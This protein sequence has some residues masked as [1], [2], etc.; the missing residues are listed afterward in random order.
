MSDLFGN[1]IVGFP[2]PNPDNDEP[3][4]VKI[5]AYVDDSQ[6]FNSTENSVKE[7]FKIFDK[8]E[9]ASGAKI[10][11][12][13]TTAMYIGPWKAKQPEFN[14]I[15]WTNTYVKTLGINHGYHIPEHEV[16]ME[17]IK[18]MKNCIQ[19]WKSRDLTLKGKILIIKTFLLSQ[20]N[21]ELEM[22]PIPKQIVKEIDKILWNFLWDGKQ[23]LVNKQTMCLDIE[24]G[25]MNMINLNSFIGAKH[26]KFIHKIVNSETQHWNMIGKY[27]LKHFDKT[28]NSNNFLYNCS[29][30]KGLTINFPSQFYKD[31]IQSWALF[32]NKLQTNHF[33]SILDENICGNNRI[34]HNNTPLWFEL[35]SKNEIKSI[36]D[37]WDVNDKNF[38]DENTILSR[39]TDKRSGLKR[40]RIIKSS[41][42]K[43]WLNTL[44]GNNDNTQVNNLNK[45]KNAIR[46]GTI[47]INNMPLKEIQCLLNENFQPKCIDRWNTVF[48]VEINWNNHWKCSFETPLSNKKKQL[49]WKIIH[50]AI[51]TEYKLSLIGRS[52]G[53]C[54][55]CKTETEYLTHLFCEC[56]V[57]QSAL[58]NINAKVNTI[59]E[60]AGHKHVKFDLKNVILGFNYDT[61]QNVHIRIYLNTVLQMVKWEIWKNRNIIKYENK[62]F[63]TAS[64]LKCIMSKIDCCVKFMQKTKTADKFKK[65]LDLLRQFENHT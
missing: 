35:F 22:N 58:T 65:I 11:K 25:G 1:H 53:K 23:P 8:F 18:K 60:Q 51:F 36:K 4:E 29:S 19:I 32:R 12:T 2:L 33:R 6:Y 52:E 3:A 46:E 7:C 59:L 37:I 62:L 34:R 39:L 16:W 5:S 54:H 42:D 24:N 31:A 55:F 61:V 47:Q 15:S 17:K 38:V 28:Y 41:I 64:L 9:K 10:H 45:R 13:K 50:N 26:I 57:I 30:L 27:W 43:E 20:I 40:Y 48:D 56:A 49:H 44:K 21:Y 14:E 63:S